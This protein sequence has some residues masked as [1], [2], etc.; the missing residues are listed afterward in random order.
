MNAVMRLR[1]RGIPL[2]GYTWWPMLAMV[3]WA[4]RQ[5]TNPPEYYLTKM[6][7]WDLKLGADGKLERIETQL[8]KKYREMILNNCEVAGE[9]K[10]DEQGVKIC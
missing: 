4:Y 10:P 1:E 3:T 7:L 8:V 6:G 5:G 9:L 2:V